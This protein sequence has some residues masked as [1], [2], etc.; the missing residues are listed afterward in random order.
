MV[1]DSWRVR[2]GAGVF[3]PASA[4]RSGWRALYPERRF[5]IR[6]AARNFR[7]VGEASKKDIVS[8]VEWLLSDRSRKKPK[9][10][11]KNL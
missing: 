4:G 6:R 8:R 5:S 2:T 10:L 11:Q 7:I 1:F 9:E 3:S